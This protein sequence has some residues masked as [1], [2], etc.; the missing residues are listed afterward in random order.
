MPTNIAKH[1]KEVKKTFSK[2][3]WIFKN[4]GFEIKLFNEEEGEPT[5]LLNPEDTHRVS[6]VLEKALK[7]ILFTGKCI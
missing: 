6:A 2:Q 7:S 1:G 3:L 4:V 5:H